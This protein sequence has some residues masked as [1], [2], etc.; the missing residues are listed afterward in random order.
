MVIIKNHQYIRGLSVK[1]LAEML[2]KTEEVNEGDER[3]DG[4]TYDWYITYF[5][6]PDGIRCY[7]FED[8]IKHTIDWLNS[9]RKEYIK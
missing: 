2:V 6:C 9:D 3:M 1:E 8:A 7:D 4:E 5:I